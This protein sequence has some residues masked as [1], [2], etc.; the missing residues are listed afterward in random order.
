MSDEVGHVLDQE[1]AGPKDGNV[2]RHHCKDAIVAI[3]A[4]VVA[5]SQLAEALAGRSRS[6]E[7]DVA[8]LSTLTTYE[9]ATF[10][11]HQVG[12]DPDLVS[13]VVV[14]DCDSLFPGVV[15]LDN[16]EPARPKAN[17]DAAKSRTK[18]DGNP[19]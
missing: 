14:V 2:L 19:G 9:F 4:V 10:L 13:E 17:P 5:V 1:E 6:D 15:R 12:G 16:P 7:V 11:A 18:L 8:D 3:A